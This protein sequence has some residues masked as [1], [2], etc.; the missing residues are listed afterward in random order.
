VEKPLWAPWRIE[1]IRAPKP[2]GCI[3]CDFPAAP[4]ADDRANLVLHRSA[5]AFTCL[6]RYPYNSGHLMVIPRAHVTELSALAPAEWA[7][8][9]DELR[10]AVEVVKA[11]YHPDGMNVGMNLA[12]AAGAGIDDHLHWHV[13]PRWAGDNNFMPVLADQRVVVQALDEA[14]EQLH[15]GFEAVRAP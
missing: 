5:R 2:A 12:R 3:F 13:V 10:R 8:L 11:T 1:Y 6:N 7:D 4:E 14:W 9:Q 15:A